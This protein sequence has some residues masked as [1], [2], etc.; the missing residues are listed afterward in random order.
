MGRFKAPSLRN[1]AVTAPYMHDGSVAS[2]DGA[3]DHYSRGGRELVEGPYT[4]DGRTNPFKSEFVQGF[5]LSDEE[6][7]DLLAFLQA[8]TDQSVLTNL[9][10]LSRCRLMA[11]LLRWA[12][13][14]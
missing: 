1:I 5:E 3:L 9:G 2:L 11:K 13:A 14:I 8:L 7:A 10:F 4:G 12:M 6:K